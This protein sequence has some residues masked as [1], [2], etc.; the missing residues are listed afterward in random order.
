M[1]QFQ[2]SESKS[3]V[4]KVGLRVKHTHELDHQK[5][6]NYSFCHVIEQLFHSPSLRLA[7][8]SRAL[9]LE[10]SALSV[11]GIFSITLSKF[12]LRFIGD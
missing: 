4:S 9:M 7:S 12:A 10:E 11:S 8:L 1:L 3:S 6:S 5:H 2:V